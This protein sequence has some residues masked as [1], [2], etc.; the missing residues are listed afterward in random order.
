MLVLKLRLK[1]TVR[2]AE[3]TLKAEG[4]RLLTAIGDAEAAEYSGA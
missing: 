4:F 2:L 3:E 1:S